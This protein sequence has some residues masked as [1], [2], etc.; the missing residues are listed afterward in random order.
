MSVTVLESIAIE[1]ERRL[2]LLVNQNTYNTNVVEVVRPI[3]LDD[4]TPQHLQI[5]LTKGAEEV[6]EELS[7]PGNP[8]SIAKKVTFNIRCIVLTDEK[9]II[10][11]DTVV[12]M[13]VADVQLVTAGL[14][15]HWYNFDSN[16]I[17]AEFLPVELISADGGI[18]GANVPIAIT[19]RHSE[20]NPYE[21]RA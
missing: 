2:N 7:Y 13:F 14:D 18:D 4:F 5:L 17:N 16:A 19:Y 21:V 20:G 10:P 8:P 9:E 11:V 6:I 12:D 1:L 15:D 3:R